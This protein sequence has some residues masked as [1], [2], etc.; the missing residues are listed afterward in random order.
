MKTIPL[1]YRGFVYAWATVDDDD[2][3]W[4]RPHRWTTSP[5]HL[6]TAM[7][8]YALARIDGKT[9]AMHRLIMGLHAG[10]GKIVHHL[11]H[12]RLD[13]R[14]ANLAVCETVQEHFRHPHPQLGAGPSFGYIP[15]RSAA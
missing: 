4:L 1:F 11:N 8:A 13:N 2:Y 3:D 9:E 10:E 12:C 15:F 7:P 14:K 5:V 6:L